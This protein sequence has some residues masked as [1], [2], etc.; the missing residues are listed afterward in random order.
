MQ[1]PEFLRV[2]DGQIRPILQW[3]G[4][5]ILAE[6]NLILQHGVFKAKSM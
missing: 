3:N 6:K 2:D 1:K 5:G 4:K